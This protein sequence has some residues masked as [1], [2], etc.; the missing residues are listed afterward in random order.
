M[1]PFRTAPKTAR[2]LAALPCAHPMAHCAS[3]D[4]G[5]VP[6]RDTRD[7]GAVPPPPDFEDSFEDF[8]GADSARQ[9]AA[10]PSETRSIITVGAGF[11]AIPLLLSASLRLSVIDP[12]LFYLQA[13]MHE[14]DLT[15]R[16][17]NDITLELD[18]LER[19]LKYDGLMGHAPRL[20]E[21]A[22]E[23][24]LREEGLR[25]EY[26]QRQKSRESVGN[27]ASDALS[28]LL[29]LAGARLNRAR[30]SKLRTGVVAR[31]LALEVSTQAFLLLLAADITVGYHSSDGWVTFLEVIF[32]RY[33]V[34]G[35]EGADNVIRLFVATVPVIIDVVFKYWVYRYLR[36]LS[37]GTQ[38]ILSE[39]ERH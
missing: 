35:A 37:P 23:E 7:G 33:S 1:S 15:A 32:G 6:P 39:I 10:L 22:L 12:L 34:N 38:I 28:T 18:G 5:G 27:T 8:P 36:K 29:L 13:D 30:L 26:E 17:W 16:Q 20:S 9:W 21:G 24:R 31:F 25:L 2:A 4:G 11:I 3:R 19:R 14:F